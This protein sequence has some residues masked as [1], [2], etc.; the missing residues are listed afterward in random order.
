[1]PRKPRVSGAYALCQ[2]IPAAGEWT[3][4]GAGA[5]FLLTKSAFSCIVYTETISIY[6]ESF[7]AMLTDRSQRAKAIRTAGSTAD[8]R[9]A[10][11]LIALEAQI[12]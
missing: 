12:L 11:L 9:L 6:I 7:Q 3:A 1:M 4:A 2:T 5:T 8:R 10:A